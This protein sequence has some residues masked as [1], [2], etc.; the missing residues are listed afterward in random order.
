MPR[1]VAAGIPL[2]VRPA[3]LAEPDVERYT[4]RLPAQ[5]IGGVGGVSQ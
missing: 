4:I 2:R 5:G 3:A 1:R